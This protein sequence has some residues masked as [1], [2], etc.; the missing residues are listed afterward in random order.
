MLLRERRDIPVKDD[1]KALRIDLPA[2]DVERVRPGV[3]TAHLN[4][5]GAA[6]VGPKH[7]SGRAITEQRRGDD[8]CLGQFV[9]PEG[10]G[11]NFDRDEQHNAARTRTGQAGCDGEPGDAASA[12]KSE[13][14]N[15]LDI[16]AKPQTPG[17]P[18]FETRRRDASREIVTMVSTSEASSSAASSAFSPPRQRVDMLPQDRR[19]CAPA[20][21]AA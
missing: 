5:R 4:G 13:D 2:H 6:V 14:G 19:W 21:P 3:L 10:E 20:S 18:R 17:Y 11:A 15:S 16:R 1:A 9:E 7:A 12:A 8:V